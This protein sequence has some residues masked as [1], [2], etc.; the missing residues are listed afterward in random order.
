KLTLNKHVYMT[1]FGNSTFS[2]NSKDKGLLEIKQLINKIAHDL[3]GNYN[4]EIQNMAQRTIVGKMVF[5]L[6]KWMVPGFNRRWRGAV[7]FKTPT[8]KLQDEV[9]NFY[10]EDLQA[11]Q[12]G[13]YT[14]ALRFIY[15]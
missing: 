10:S 14:T 2:L 13:Y 12:E 6:R 5:M 3:H 15:N 7:H 8:D 9:D 4:D 1:N 11:F